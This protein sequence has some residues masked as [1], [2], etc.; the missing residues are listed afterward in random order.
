MFNWFSVLYKEENEILKTF[1]NFDVIAL[2]LVH[3]RNLT[4][5]FK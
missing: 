3:V 5:L 1:E 4:E 2:F